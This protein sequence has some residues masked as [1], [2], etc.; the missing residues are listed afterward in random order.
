M[1]TLKNLPDIIEQAQSKVA[2]NGAGSSKRDESMIARV[3]SVAFV[4]VPLA[5]AIAIFA[6]PAA[7]QKVSRDEAQQACEADV[8]RLCDEY[9]PNETEIAACLKK[10][11]KHLSPACRKV[12]THS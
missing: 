4:F 10:E 9:I 7:A 2:R 8:H 6:S 3:I 12:V 5:A 11:L 1:K